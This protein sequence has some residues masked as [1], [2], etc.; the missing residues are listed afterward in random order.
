MNKHIVQIV[1]GLT[2]AAIVGGVYYWSVRPRP[3]APLSLSAES[4]GLMGVPVGQVSTSGE[5]ATTQ[6]L[7]ADLNDDG[8]PETVFQLG[9]ERGDGYLLPVSFWIESTMRTVRVPGIVIYPAYP[10][11]NRRPTKELIVYHPETQRLQRLRRVGN[12][13]RGEDIAAPMVSITYQRR[14]SAG[15]YYDLQLLTPHA[16]WFD[17][18]GDG[19]DDAIGVLQ[20]NGEPFALTLTEAGR[21]V[22]SRYY[23]LLKPSARLDSEQLMQTALT[24]YHRLCWIGDL[25]N[26]RRPDWFDLTTRTFQMSD[27]ETHSIDEPLR[28][29][30]QWLG[31]NLDGQQPYELVYCA[32]TPR[33]ALVRIYRHNSWSFDRIAEQHYLDRE[34]HVRVSDLNS[35]GIDELVVGALLDTGTLFEL[36][37]LR[38]QDASLAER[39]LYAT[40]LPPRS[41]CNLPRFPTRRTAAFCLYARKDEV[42]DQYIPRTLFVSQQTGSERP[43]LALVLGV[44]VWGG[45]YDGDGNEEYALS[46]AHARHE[47]CSLIHFRDGRWRRHIPQVIGIMKTAF[48]VYVRGDARLG[49]VYFDGGI[50][51]IRF[52]PTP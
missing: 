20:R 36:Y 50:S 6:S 16:D 43:R 44:P 31:A 14:M 21:W 27:G 29:N 38:L 40:R 28:P 1:F 34:V 33:G 25:D 26:D 11:G 5:A 45:D 24:P 7:L 51:A 10:S 32:K 22:P 8:E 2:V 41:L 3:E 48:P 17:S 39:R 4:Y 49:V 35:D 12:T 42:N 18:D 15:G 46:T 52:K 19:F 13:W 9:F 30:E 47:P 37:H 23:S